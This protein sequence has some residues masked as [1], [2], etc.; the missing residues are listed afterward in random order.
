[1]VLGKKAMARVRHPPPA[2]RPTTSNIDIKQKFATCTGP[3]PALPEKVRPNDHLIDRERTQRF[4]FTSHNT[5]LCK[6]MYI[7]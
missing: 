2:A 5:V 7:L 6:Q 3:R 4:G 1:M